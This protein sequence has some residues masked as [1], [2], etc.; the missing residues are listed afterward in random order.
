MHC[1]FVFPYNTS[2]SIFLLYFM[3]PILFICL[4]LLNS[5]FVLIELRSSSRRSPPTTKCTLILSRGC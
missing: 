3:H 2:P 4:F 5:F 1:F